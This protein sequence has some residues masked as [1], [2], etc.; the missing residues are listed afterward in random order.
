[1][2]AVIFFAAVASMHFACPSCGQDLA[3]AIPGGLKCANGH[4]INVAKEGHVHMLPPVKVNAQAQAASDSV[5]RAQRAFY[6]HG[7]YAAQLDAVAAE[8]HRALQACP[9]YPDAADEMHVLNAGCGEG[10]CLR[11]LE[12]RLE[13]DGVRL[14]GLWGTDTSKLAVRYAAKRQRTAR[15]AV[16]APHQLPFRDGSMHVVFSLL[17]PSPPWEE[18]CR[19]LRPGGAVV[20]ARAGNRHLRELRPSDAFASDEPKQFAAGL[21]EQYV[22]VCTEERY[23]GALATE[24]L[25]MAGVGGASDTLLDSGSGEVQLAAP[26]TVDLICS[27]HRV[28][29][30]TGGE[31]SLGC[32]P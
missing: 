21:A 11:L 8:V 18:S 27:T 32:L 15:F 31:D 30:G 19:V 23:R 17:A 7:G 9:E 20:V 13:A 14:G 26:V 22:R 10:E 16:C 1:M 2:T 29:L 4:T 24:L 28:W 25:A 12:Q 6:E 3:I 5:V